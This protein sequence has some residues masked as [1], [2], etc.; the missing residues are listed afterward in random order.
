ME[1]TASLASFHYYQ[2]TERKARALLMSAKLPLYALNSSP[3]SSTAPH[4]RP[5][6]ALEFLTPFDTTLTPLRAQY[7][8]TRGKP[9][10]GKPLRYAGF[11]SP[12]KPLQHLTDHS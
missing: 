4:V 12:S 10:K 3:E 7:G 2:S 1:R 6:L 5:A 9:E 11:A 8:A